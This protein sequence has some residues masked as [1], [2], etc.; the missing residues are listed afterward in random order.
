MSNSARVGEIF[1]A[2]GNAFNLLG[3]LTSQLDS[4]GSRS[5]GSGAKWTDQ[6]I[7]MLQTTVTNFAAD[8][9]KISGI[10]KKKQVKQVGD[11]STFPMEASAFMKHT[12]KCITH[13]V[14]TEEI[15]LE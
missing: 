3:N 11:L 5:S 10:M 14:F 15:I 8:L 7:E 9:A 13:E 1:S 6:E 4:A 12:L 2:A